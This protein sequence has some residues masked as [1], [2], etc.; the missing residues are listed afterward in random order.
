MD[1]GLAG[2][3]MASGL[4]IIL[5]LIFLGFFLLKKFGHKAG[6][7]VGGNSSLKLMSSLSLGPK[8]SIVVV[9]FLNRDLVLGVTDSRINLL[10]ETQAHDKSEENFSQVLSESSDRDSP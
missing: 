4:L 9:R 8:K 10:T 7:R 1:M 2:V 6:F 3:K 5:G